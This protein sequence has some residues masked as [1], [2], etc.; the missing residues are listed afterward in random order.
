MMLDCFLVGLRRT[1]M[2][3]TRVINRFVCGV[4]ILVLLIFGTLP[5]ETKAKADFPAAGDTFSPV[6]CSASAES[7]PG[8]SPASLGSAD[9]RI[10][11]FCNPN[12][13][14]TTTVKDAST[15]LPLSQVTI[16]IT[17]IPPGS[18]FAN[19]NLSNTNNSGELETY[20]FVTDANGV[21]AYTVQGKVLNWT[22]TKQGYVTRLGRGLP[23]VSFGML[24]HGFPPGSW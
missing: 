9:C 13:T 3:G 6:V 8:N 20:T 11:L 17:T 1:L 16:T 2:P 19:S 12:C 22:A 14:G 10:G 15:G 21:A 18:S 24:P 5:V 23:P 7:A 4:L